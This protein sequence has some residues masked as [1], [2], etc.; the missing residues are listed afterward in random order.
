MDCSTRAPGEVVRVSP[1]DTTDTGRRPDGG[2]ISG[3]ES[4]LSGDSPFDVVSDTDLSRRD[5]YHNWIEAVLLTPARVI[6]E[7]VRARVGL[8]IILFYV[9]MGTVGVYVVDPPST[10]GPS[11]APPFQSLAYPLGT[12]ALG[13]DI[14]ALIVYSTP[15]MLLMLASGA[16]FTTVLATAVG[17]LSGY[18]GGAVDRVLMI[19]SDIMM[20]IPGLPLIIVLAVIFS[21]RNPLLVGIIIS[22][23]AWAGL[24][25]SIRSQVL[26]LRES[27]YVEASRTMGVSTNIIITDDLLPNLMPY[28]LM[29]FVAAGRR[30]IFNSVALYFIGALPFSQLNWGVILNMAYQK[31]ALYYW[32][33]IHWVIAPLVTILLITVGLILFAQ[34]TERLFNP[35]IRARHKEGTADVESAAPSEDTQTPSTFR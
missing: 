32:D 1:T 14:L 33:G 31:G 13:Q 15:S 35:R 18:K 4:D 8:A 28:I 21:P 3:S 16:V 10:A 23:N 26:T 5:R 25:R 17:T 20:S 24:A 29:N 19:V 7:D 12:D 30:V 11:L 27:N 9:L 34:G 2:S 6:W 22:T